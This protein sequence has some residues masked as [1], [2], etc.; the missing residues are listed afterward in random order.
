MIR[1]EP[2]QSGSGRFLSGLSQLAEQFL[3]CRVVTD[4]FEV[5]VGFEAHDVGPAALLALCGGN[6]RPPLCSAWSGRHRCQR[7]PRR[8][9]SRRRPGSRDVHPWAESPTSAWA[10]LAASACSPQRASAT[11]RLTCGILTFGSF[12]SALRIS[13]Q[14]RYPAA[15]AGGVARVEC[16]GRL[17]IKRLG[18]HGL[19]C[20]RSVG[21]ASAR[22]SDQVEGLAVEHPRRRRVAALGVSAGTRHCC[23]TWR[24]RR[25][26]A[27]SRAVPPPTCSR[28][29]LQRS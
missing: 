19:G 7:H 25:R 8:E 11:M 17:V 23:M 1:P 5:G 12:A 27:R 21:S 24:G 20:R 22:F 28:S 6:R 14:R 10:I 3:E 18:E 9:R 26:P 15:A 29:A 4:R 2:C 13:R 16:A